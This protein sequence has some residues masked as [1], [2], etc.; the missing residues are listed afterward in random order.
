[1]KYF[2]ILLSLILSGCATLKVGDITYTRLGNQTI[3]CK[4]KT[5]T[6]GSMEVEFKQNSKSEAMKVLVNAAASYAN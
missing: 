6:D 2:L 5:S 4:I 3:E 1:M